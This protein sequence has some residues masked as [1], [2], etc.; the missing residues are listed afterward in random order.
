MHNDIIITKDKDG[1][2]TIPL[3]L[4]EKIKISN[5]RALHGVPVSI[6]IDTNRAQSQIGIAHQSPNLLDARDY[7]KLSKPAIKDRLHH[8]GVEIQQPY[9]K[10]GFINDREGKITIRHNEYL[11]NVKEFHRALEMANDAQTNGLIPLALQLI[12][13]LSRSLEKNLLHYTYMPRVLFNI[14]THYADEFRTP[15]RY[16]ERRL[17]HPDKIRVVTTTDMTFLI[18]FFPQLIASEIYYL[19]SDKETHLLLRK[20]NEI[21]LTAVKAVNY[22]DWEPH[23]HMVRRLINQDKIPG[24]TVKPKQYEDTRNHILQYF[25]Y[26]CSR[27]TRAERT[28]IY[29]T[30]RPTPSYPDVIIRS[31]DLLPREKQLADENQPIT[32]VEKAIQSI[33]VKEHLIIQ[34]RRFIAQFMYEETQELIL[35]VLTSINTSAGFVPKHGPIYD[36]IKTIDIILKLVVEKST[37]HLINYEPVYID[38][39]WDKTIEEWPDFW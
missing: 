39:S 33:P 2:F 19:F 25:D 21:R 37:T 15:L 32:F 36:N 17:F 30:N 27:A 8:L 1:Y 35:R 31:N 9:N 18:R 11:T 14:M 7:I 38:T 28:H 24:I 13:D 34:I 26:F 5:P 6:V 29:L 16:I 3:H 4:A 23:H 12:E 10:K 22:P 20:R